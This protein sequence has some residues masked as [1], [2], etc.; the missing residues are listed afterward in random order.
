MES[1]NKNTVSNIS[2]KYIKLCEITKHLKKDI[3]EVQKMINSKVAD[4]N[5]KLSD[6][7]INDKFM[8]ILLEINTIGKCST[9]IDEVCETIANNIKTILENLPIEEDDSVNNVKKSLTEILKYIE[10]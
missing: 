4:D 9:K 7:D 1:V 8:V 3:D 5:N 10:K 6:I 2:K